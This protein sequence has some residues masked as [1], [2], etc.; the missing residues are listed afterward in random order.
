MTP[1]V[2]F[3]PSVVIKDVESAP[4]EFDFTTSFLFYDRFSIGGTYRTGDGIGVL[5]QLEATKQLRVGYAYDYP[6]SRIS[7]GIENLSQAT[8]ELMLSIEFK[9]KDVTRKNK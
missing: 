2:R 3:K 4:F 7:E 8:H 9:F 1:T 6:F 5:L